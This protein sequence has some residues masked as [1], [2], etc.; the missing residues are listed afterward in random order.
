MDVHLYASH[1]D[2]PYWGAANP[3]WG[4]FVPY[5]MRDWVFHT[6]GPTEPLQEGLKGTVWAFLNA[7][8]QM[9]RPQLEAHVSIGVPISDGSEV[10]IECSHRMWIQI[11]A[12]SAV[13]APSREANND[14]SAC[15]WGKDNRTHRFANLF[16]DQEWVEFQC[17]GT[18]EERISFV[19]SFFERQLHRVQQLRTERIIDLSNTA[20]A[21]ARAVQAIL[22]TE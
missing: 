5:Q 15:V 10:M 21:H 11:I 18:V 16:S 14:E 3:A 22:A 13:P 20:A 8:Y 6:V 4:R 1:H 12:P 19:Q 9:R 17:L 7:L 2:L